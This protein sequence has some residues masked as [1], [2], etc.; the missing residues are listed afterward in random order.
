[1]EAKNLVI[2]DE[3]DLKGYLVKRYSSR[4]GHPLRRY[5]N[6]T[7][8]GGVSISPDIDLL[9]IDQANKV[10]TGYEFKLLKFKKAPSNYLRIRDGMAEAIQYFQF[11]IDRAYMVLGISSRIPKKTAGLVGASH[12]ELLALVRALVVT[13]GFDCLGLMLWLEDSDRLLTP[14]NPRSNF[15][16]H[17]LKGHSQFRNFSLNRE[18]LFNS[19]F[20][21]NRKFPQKY[22]LPTPPW[23][24]RY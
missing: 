12:I 10:L 21:W 6:I 5:P 1:M 7:K 17:L 16:L 3:D 2:G 18:L 13:H 8:I 19:K 14:Q 20:S 15:P 4:F 9:D 23:G 22:N 11:G 24:I